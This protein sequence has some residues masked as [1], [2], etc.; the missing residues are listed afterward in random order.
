MWILFIHDCN[1]TIFIV[2]IKTFFS[3]HWK[4]VIDMRQNSKKEIGLELVMST[5]KENPYLA[6]F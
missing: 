4:I 1:F 6:Y 2:L 3:R 5:E